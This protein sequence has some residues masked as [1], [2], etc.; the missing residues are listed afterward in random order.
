VGK[1]GILPVSETGD[2]AFKSLPADQTVR[3]TM[4]V[5]WFWEPVYGC[6]IH[7]APIKKIFFFYFTFTG[8]LD[9]SATLHK[10]YDNQRDV[11]YVIKCDCGN[12]F[13]VKCENESA[14]NYCPAC[15]AIIERK[16]PNQGVTK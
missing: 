11:V 5:R 10:I 6:S 14:I 15:A 8:D 2:R 1:S 4:A 16:K 7:P 13:T 12:N 3:G 9:V